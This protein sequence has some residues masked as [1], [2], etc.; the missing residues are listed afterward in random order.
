MIKIL[1]TIFISSFLFVACCTS[2]NI[3]I[4]DR[5]IPEKIQIK[6]NEFIISK[7][8]K[9]FFDKYLKPD[10]N[11]TIEVKDGYQVVY[12]FSIPEKEIDAIIKFSTDTLGNIKRNKEIAGIPG[13]VSTP[14]DCS[15]I[16]SKND[17]I[18]IASSSGLE[19][20]VKEWAVKFTWDSTRKKYLWDIT[21]TLRETKGDGFERA[22]GKTM[23]IDPN[24]G[25]IVE[26]NA[27]QIN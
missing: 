14:E 20:G 25:E 2:S 8:G 11:K 9:E 4:Q 13:C 1:L 26:T 18:K 21:S 6:T 27:W 15:F 24:N 10:Y 12:S 17:A 7:T 22:S 5:N 16:I 3:S 23:L 19:R